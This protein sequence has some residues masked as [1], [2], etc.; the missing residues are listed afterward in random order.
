LPSS[1]DAIHPFVSWPA[2]GAVDALFTPLTRWDAGNY[3][4]IVRNGYGYSDGDEASPLS[5]FFPLY[6]ALT[7]L[8]AWVLGSSYAAM[9]IASYLVSLLAFLGALVLFC[10]LVTLEFGAAVARDA[11]LLLAIFP[12]SFYFS[13]PYSESLFLLC[14]VGAFY[15]GRTGRWG[16]AGVAGACATATRLVGVAL[17]VPL[18]L[19][20]F[21]GPRPDP[22]LDG[23]RGL[24]PRYPLRRD[25]SWLALVPAGVIA[26]TIYLQVAFG[27]GFAWFH[28]QKTTFARVT[29][30]PTS[31]AWAGVTA[32]WHAARRLEEIYG[33]AAPPGVFWDWEAQQASVAILE[34][35]VLLLA[36]ACLVGVFRRLPI[37][38]GAY[39]ATALVILLSSRV[40]T[41]PP[42]D[43]G[44]P[45]QS[46]HR[47]V[48]VLFP[49][50]VWLGVEAQK[51]RWTPSL[52]A[53]FGIF[54]GLFTAM[55]SLS[56]WLV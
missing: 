36:C 35:G 2:G 14:S 17:I 34:F 50:F 12:A 20:Y 15:A 28:A 54:L 26:Y 43:I 44:R 56:Y 1:G 19:L 51:R 22:P 42:I 7:R 30:L 46:L 53:A 52:A 9:L 21:Y 24:R 4:A 39:T 3:L 45:L 47:F 49:Y 23:R 41:A 16:W 55:F 13:S 25:V 48:A 6:P 27:D 5:A 32:A 37:A 40:S 31:T 29:S 10:K 8:V 38:Y 18:A 33:P 11:T